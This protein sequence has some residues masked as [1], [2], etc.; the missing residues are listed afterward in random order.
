MERILKKLL[1]CL[2]FA[3]CHL[4]GDRAFDLR[5]NRALPRWP[6]AFLGSRPVAGGRPVAAVEV[7]PTRGVPTPAAREGGEL[8]PHGTDAMFRRLCGG[9]QCCSGRVR[10]ARRFFSRRHRYASRRPAVKSGAWCALAFLILC[11][12]RCRRVDRMVGDVLAVKAKDGGRMFF[13]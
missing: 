5:K 11:Y 6:W 13:K 1:F 10:H 3:L 8:E 7:S 9:A 4:L 2:P 12:V